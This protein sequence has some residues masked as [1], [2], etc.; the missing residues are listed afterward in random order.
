MKDCPPGF[1]GSLKST[2]SAIQSTGVRG[3]LL[4]INTYPFYLNLGIVTLFAAVMLLIGSIL[5]S[6]M[7]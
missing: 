4:G 5:F 3:A 6:R 2:R 7:K 1:R